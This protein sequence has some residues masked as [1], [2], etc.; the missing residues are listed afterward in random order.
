MSPGFQSSTISPSVPIDRKMTI[1][2]GLISVSSTFFQNDMSTRSI[3]APAEW[4]TKPFGLVLRPSICSSRAGRLGATTSITFCA[5]ASRAFR[6]DARRTAASAHL[7]L[8][9]CSLARARSEAAASF[10]T[11]RLRSSWMSSP[12]TE[13]GVEEPMLVCGDIAR[14]SAAW[15]IQTPAEAARAPSGET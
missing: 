7:A 1:S 2:S 9:P 11:L 4:R 8:R 12:P 6:F 5:S 15:P 10:T 3:S 14:M 13:I